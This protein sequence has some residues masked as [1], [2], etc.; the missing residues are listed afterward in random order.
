[1]KMFSM[2]YTS[3]KKFLQEFALLP[4]YTAVSIMQSIKTVLRS[5]VTTSDNNKPLLAMENPY[6]MHTVLILKKKALS[7]FLT[8]MTLVQDRL[9]ACTSI[10][11]V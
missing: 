1:M 10:D 11:T 8:C 2:L 7:I 6:M 5:I 4:N 9:P 3:T